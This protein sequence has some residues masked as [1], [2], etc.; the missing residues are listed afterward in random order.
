MLRKVI[1]VLILVVLYK[2]QLA[3]AQLVMPAPERLND[4]RF[5]PP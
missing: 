5:T 2:A 1:N 4:P 3:K